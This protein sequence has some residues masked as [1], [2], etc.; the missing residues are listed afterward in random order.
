M[1]ASLRGSAAGSN[2]RT[3]G[4]YGPAAAPSASASGRN[5]ISY[6]SSSSLVR[7]LLLFLCPVFVMLFIYMIVKLDGSPFALLQ[8]F[9]QNGLGSTV[10]AAWVPYI[11]GSARAWK[12]IILFAVL[13]LVLMRILPGKLT[14]GPVTPAGNVPVYKANGTLAFVVT[15]VVFCICAFVLRLFNPADIYDHFLE[16]IGA[17][18]VFSLIFC[19]GLYLKGRF[20]PSSTDCS[21]TGVFLFDYYWGTELYPRVLG[22]DVK[23][24][25]NCRFGLMVWGLLV[26][27]YATKQYE[28][29]G[30][31]DSMIVSVALQLIYIG[32]FFHWEMG[33]MKS[34]DIMHDRGGFYL[35][36]FVVHPCACV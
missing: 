22:W 5:M 27:S 10:Y 23:M 6:T 11:F 18:N 32:K 4:S 7:V 3:I 16:F 2:G 9:R 35:V 17:M 31:S 13:Q 30:L 33:Y 20:A 36:S 19:F 26:L 25:T 8:E 15:L 14:K 12:L 21:V 28:T 24:F 1:K 29:H 34:L